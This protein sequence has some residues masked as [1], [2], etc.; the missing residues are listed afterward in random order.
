MNKLLTLIFLSSSITCET[1]FGEITGH[2]RNDGKNGYAGSS[3]KAITAFYLCGGR[4]YRVHYLGDDKNTW[5]Q[6]YC[7][8]EPVGIGRSIDA[9]S[10]SGGKIYSVR[11]KNG[12]WG[13]KITGYNI[14]D[15]KKG[16][17]GSLGK[18]IDAILIE[19]GDIYRV[20]YGGESSSVE[21]V[22]KRVVKNLFG[23]DYTYDFE[24]ETIVKE[25]KYIRVTVKLERS[26]NYNAKSYI[27]YVIKN[28][29]LVDINIGDF[30]NILEELKKVVFF[31]IKSVQSKFEYSFT[32]GMCN[33]SVKIMINWLQKKIE[34]YTG[35]KITDNHNSFRGGFRITI[36]IKDDINDLKQTFLAPCSVFLKRLGVV[37]EKILE[38]ITRFLNNVWEILEKIC[39]RILESLP[40][41]VCDF[42]LII[43]FIFLFPFLA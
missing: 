25:D 20:A 18:E 27:N 22:S 21:E 16:Y 40:E 42:I 5:T 39:E 30:G 4:N 43:L 19:G 14:Y 41:I 10:I 26:Y 17:A 32:R 12:R 38:L 23:L 13:G 36:Y 31:D 35:S 24:H 37:G 15:S 29:K 33:G 2:D 3:G 1:W 28:N 7:C 34:I 9:I 8:C 6:E 11:F